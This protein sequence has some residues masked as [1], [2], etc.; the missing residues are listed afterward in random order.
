M[1]K[2]RRVLTNLIISQLLSSQ[3]AYIKLGCKPKVRPT[4]RPQITLDMSFEENFVSN[5]E[6]PTE[7]FGMTFKRP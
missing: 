7:Q 2:S 3:L 5:S 4:L 6:D 1:E